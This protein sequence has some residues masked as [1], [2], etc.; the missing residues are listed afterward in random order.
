MKI[1]AKNIWR[2]RAEKEIILFSKVEE[3]YKSDTK[4]KT[5]LD[6]ANNDKNP[7]QLWGNEN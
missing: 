4:D 2:Q 5:E 7:L 3:K 6:K 1:K